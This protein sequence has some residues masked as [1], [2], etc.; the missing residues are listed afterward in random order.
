M[1]P[2]MHFGH[3]ISGIAHF[4]FLL[5]LFL[6]NIFDPRLPQPRPPDEF[7][8]GGASEQEFQAT[9]DIVE[10][11]VVSA[12]TAVDILSPSPDDKLEP[13]EPKIDKKVAEVTPEIPKVPE[14]PQDKIDLPKKIQIVEP[15]LS[16]EPEQPVLSQDNPSI[17]PLPETTDAQSPVIADR[18]AS[19]PVIPQNEDAFNDDLF[20][21]Q[22][23]AD[24]EQEKLDLMLEQEKKSKLGATTEII[25]E[26][27]KKPSG[28]PKRSLRPKG[29]PQIQTASEEK[30]PRSKDVVDAVSS[31]LSSIAN[32]KESLES[33]DVVSN[34][35][36]NATANTASIGSA[37]LKQIEPCW[38]VDV[39][40]QNAYVKVTVAFSLD[41]N[42][43]IER[44][45]IRL[46][47]SEGGNGSAARSAFTNAKK[48]IFKCQKKWDGF[49]LQD[50][51]YEQWQQIVLTFN[52]DQMRNR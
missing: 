40:N 42:G 52:P 23:Q 28:A 47:A 7:E 25:T 43:K 1:R 20:D 50:F 30:E 49:N 26:L 41:K 17:S 48:T 19:V 15:E 36:Q 32:E 33:T 35:S 24:A 4:G 8:I 22:S 51:D 29:R 44:N 38:N 34:I 46:V 10:L 37:L 2:E 12:Q 18:V 45:E 13:K 3:I 9:R 11:P 14:L 5:W 39:G 27:K 31:A 16:S 6:G 21:S